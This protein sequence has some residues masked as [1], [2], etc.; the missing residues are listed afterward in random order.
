MSAL[1][2]VP[3]PKAAGTAGSVSENVTAPAPPNW[4]GADLAVNACKFLL[5]K[6]PC[7]VILHMRKAFPFLIRLAKT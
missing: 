5:A 4:N 2:W 6:P 1:P 7:F 3:A